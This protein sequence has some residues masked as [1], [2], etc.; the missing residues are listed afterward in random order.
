[1]ARTSHAQ[2]PRARWVK[3]KSIRILSDPGLPLTTCHDPADIQLGFF[4]ALRKDQDHSR[5]GGP[6]NMLE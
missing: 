4:L 5:A 1:M 2:S 6:W 3:T